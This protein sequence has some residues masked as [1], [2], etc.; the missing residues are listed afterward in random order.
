MLPVDLAVSR[1]HTYTMPRVSRLGDTYRERSSGIRSGP[2]SQAG[3]GR[4]RPDLSNNAGSRSVI[5]PWTTGIRWAVTVNRR[6]ANM[7]TEGGF[8]EAPERNHSNLPLARLS[9]ERRQWHSDLF[10]PHPSKCEA[11]STDVLP[12]V[13]GSRA[14]AGGHWPGCHCPGRIPPLPTK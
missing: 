7:G 13:R 3:W 10:H 11:S 9:S 4:P 8:G 2:L 5:E 14:T 6:C 12:G 1:L